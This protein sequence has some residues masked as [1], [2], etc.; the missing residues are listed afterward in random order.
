MVK[1]IQRMVSTQGTELL[2]SDDDDDVKPV[3][4]Q[5]ITHD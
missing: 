4:V 1:K 5:I 2:D 3:P